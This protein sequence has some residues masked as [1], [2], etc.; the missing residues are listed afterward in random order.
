MS[1]DLDM[2][3]VLWLRRVV[4]ILRSIRSR[5]AILLLR[6]CISERNQSACP[7]SIMYVQEVIHRRTSHIGLV[8]FDTLLIC[9]C[10]VLAEAVLSMR[11]MLHTRQR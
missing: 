5:T 1:E 10:L 4:S 11:A 3:L 6:I 7:M 9:T 2:V 8:L